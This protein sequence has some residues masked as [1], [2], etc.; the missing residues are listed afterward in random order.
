MHSRAKDNTQ[1]LM[2]RTF[3]AIFSFCEHLASRRLRVKASRTTGNQRNIGVWTAQQFKSI[4]GLFRPVKTREEYIC[5]KH[6]GT[7][8]VGWC[9]AAQLTRPQREAH[10]RAVLS[11]GCKQQAS[12]ARC[13]GRWPRRHNGGGNSNRQDGSRCNSRRSASRG[14]CRDACLGCS[15]GNG[16]SCGG[17]DLQQGSCVKFVGCASC[18]AGQH[19]K[20]AVESMLSHGSLVVSP[21]AQQLTPVQWPG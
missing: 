20:Q 7:N 11:S 4:T 6:W 19:C 1:H 9:Q 18:A 15:L 2:P 16:L 3:D 13:N 5:A 21:S 10:L 12:A 14:N 17:V 8:K